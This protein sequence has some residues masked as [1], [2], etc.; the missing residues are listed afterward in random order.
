MT[1][2]PIRNR[3]SQ[4]LINCDFTTPSPSVAFRSEYMYQQQNSPGDEE[5][6][7]SYGA[8]DKAASAVRWRADSAVVHWAVLDLIEYKRCAVLM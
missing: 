3:N 1:L 2:K 7:S 5:T 4:T 6:C 8:M